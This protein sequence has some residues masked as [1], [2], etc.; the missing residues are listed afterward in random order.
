MRQGYSVY[1]GRNL[2]KEIDFIAQRH[3]EKIY[4]QVAYVL[5]DQE[6]IQREFGNLLLIKDNYPKWVITLDDLSLGNIQGVLHKSIW[7]VL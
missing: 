1:V 5:P 2:D 4:I 3:Q 7:E 6:V